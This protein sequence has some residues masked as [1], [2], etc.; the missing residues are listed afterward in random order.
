MMTIQTGLKGLT[1]TVFF[2]V[3]F[4]TVIYVLSDAAGVLTLGRDA[5]GVLIRLFVI[6]APASL[7]LS[8]VSLINLDGNRF[9]WYSLVSGFEVAILVLV[10]LIVYKSQI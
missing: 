2:A 7:F 5:G 3:L 10:F 4:I 1:D 8:L 9:K 6:G